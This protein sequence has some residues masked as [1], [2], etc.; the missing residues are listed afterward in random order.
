M[1]RDELLLECLQEYIRRTRE[2][3]AARALELRKIATPE[4]DRKYYA[5]QPEWK[6]RQELV[7]KSRG[8]RCDICGLSGRQLHAHHISYDS[9]GMEQFSD[10]TVVCDECHPIVTQRTAHLRWKARSAAYE[11]PKEEV[12]HTMQVAEERRLMDL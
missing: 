12:R 1:S 8:G 3:T 9:V 10:F 4:E 2:I 7:V 11:H 6:W 5:R